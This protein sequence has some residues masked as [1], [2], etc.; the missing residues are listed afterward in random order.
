MSVNTEGIKYVYDIN[1][2]AEYQRRHTL[3]MVFWHKIREKIVQQMKQM[4]N[5]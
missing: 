4:I 1:I 2:G 5:Y 3:K